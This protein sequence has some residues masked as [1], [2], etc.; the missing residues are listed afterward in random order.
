MTDDGEPVVLY[1]G[2]TTA[3]QDNDGPALTQSGD[4]LETSFYIAPEQIQ[5]ETKEADHRVDAWAMGVMLYEV[6]AGQRPFTGATRDA[7]Y[8]A[9]L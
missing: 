9:I 8:R 2:L 7:R 5:G 1:F 4:V 3:L 6:V